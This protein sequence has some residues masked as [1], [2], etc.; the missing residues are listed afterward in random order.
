MSRIKAKLEESNPDRVETFMAGITGEVKKI[1]GN[2]KN[3]QVPIQSQ[4]IHSVV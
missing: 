3:Y 4:V 2:I 1:V